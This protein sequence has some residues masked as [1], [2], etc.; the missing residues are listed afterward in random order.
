V[1]GSECAVTVTRLPGG[2]VPVMVGWALGVE[3]PP[4][5]EPE[6]DEIEES[7]MAGEGE[8]DGLGVGL[9]VTVGAGVVTGG[10]EAIARVYA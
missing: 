4:D 10:G 7:V 2:A 3:Y 9:G 8:A 1:T 6:A 5:M